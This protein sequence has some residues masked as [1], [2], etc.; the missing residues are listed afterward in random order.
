MKKKRI[1]FILHYP[2][3]IHGSSIVGHYIKSSIK[4]NCSFDC[5]FI[6]LGTST[7]IDEIG[8]NPINK[9][10]RYFLILWQILK[11]LHHC[12]PCLCYIAINSKGSGFYKDVP[13][14]LLIK[15]FNVKLVYHF[16]N[17]GIQSNQN[18]WFDNLL[19]KSIFKNV[20]V[21]LLSKFLYP[22]I[23]KYFEED[24]LFYCP[25]GIQ[26]VN[27][28]KQAQNFNHSSVKILFLSNL[29]ES[30]GLYI[31]LEACKLLHNRK[32]PFK[33]I[34]VGEEGDISK[35]QLENRIDEI[36]LNGSV[37]YYGKKIGCE[38]DEL[39]TGVDIFVH[40][41]VEDCFPLV[42]LEA[43]QHSL[44]IVST[45][46]GGIPE[47]IDDEISGFLVQKNDAQALSEKLELL[48]LNPQ[49]RNK[50]GVAG[51]KKFENNFTLEIFENNITNILIKISNDPN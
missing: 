35:K 39:L 41:T 3:P 38:K 9:V 31:L 50:M 30:K 42:L 24:R 36:G 19:Y 32:I 27:I 33:C 13:I 18:K 5:H 37:N 25:N 47:I 4:V 40:P 45:I 26:K 15:M 51:L 1:L 6:N 20:D 34:I 10:K 12:K 14:V 17:K 7:T 11:Q 28:Q 29:I 49:L 8:K 43:M 46:E 22:D 2:P 44:P 48:I 16:H 23:K 21:I